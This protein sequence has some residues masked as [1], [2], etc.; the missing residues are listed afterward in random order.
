MKWL[1]TGGRSITDVSLIE[2]HLDTMFKKYGKP[3]VLIHGDCSGV[4][5]ISGSW[6]EKNKITVKTFPAEW[7]RYGRAAGPIRN[8]Q[9]ADECSKEDLCVS[10]WNGSSS[11]T[12]DMLGV[13]EKKGMKTE[14]KIVK[15]KENGNES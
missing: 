11:G 5:K 10:V 12:K 3:E 13:C 2:E 15:V 6:A 9:M 14:V 4:D 7:K 8:R 1:V